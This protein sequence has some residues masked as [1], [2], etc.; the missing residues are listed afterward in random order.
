M[1]I[2]LK[3][4]KIQEVPLLLYSSDNTGYFTSML[5]ANERIAYFP[6]VHARKEILCPIKK[7]PLDFFV[8]RHIFLRI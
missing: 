2:Y 5:E 1:I 3:L 6:L 7:A 8:K 4:Q